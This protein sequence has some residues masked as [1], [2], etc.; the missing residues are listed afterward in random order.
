MWPVA[1]RRAL[2]PA[3]RTDHPRQ[4]Q[5]RGARRESA[6]PGRPRG[7]RGRSAGGPSRVGLAATLLAAALLAVSRCGRGDVGRSLFGFAAPASGRMRQDRMRQERKKQA[8]ADRKA[9]AALEAEFLRSIDQG[10][11][12]GVDPLGLADQVAR[13]KT[14]PLSER[15]RLLSGDWRLRTSDAGDILVQF[16]SGL[17]GLPFVTVQHFFLSV[18]P[19]SKQLRA[20]EVLSVGPAKGVTTILKGELRYEEDD[21]VLQYTGMVDKEGSETRT[22]EKDASRKLTAQVLYTGLRSLILRVKPTSERKGGLAV[23]ERQADFADALKE[24]TGE[25]IKVLPAGR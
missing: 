8:A 21:L 15:R 12:A 3:A 4:G 6:A 10:I 25:N 23:F 24:V 14:W 18:R 2:D 13:L 7:R 1:L 17:H 19:T 11:G 20:I 16:G 22:E 5:R 9:A